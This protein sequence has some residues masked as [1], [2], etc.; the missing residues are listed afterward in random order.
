M[1]NSNDDN[2]GEDSPVSIGLSNKPEIKEMQEK[3]LEI[4]KMHN[5][6]RR[7]TEVSNQNI[8]NHITNLE[9]DVKE[10]HKDSHR[11]D[12]ELVTFKMFMA[13]TQK[14]NLSNQIVDLRNKLEQ[15]EKQVA[16]NQTKMTMIY[17][18]CSALIAIAAIVA[19]IALKL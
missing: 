4:L 5:E 10:A 16:I 3:M 9:E 18:A 7:R 12:N 1:D 2:N 6:L 13:E 17:L 11:N 19:P 15:T 8:M 14:Q